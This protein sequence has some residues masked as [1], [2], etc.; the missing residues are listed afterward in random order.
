MELTI[1]VTGDDYPCYY[2]VIAIILFNLYI[3]S[4]FLKSGIVV[5]RGRFGE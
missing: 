1:I 4:Y 5:D 2:F 3:I